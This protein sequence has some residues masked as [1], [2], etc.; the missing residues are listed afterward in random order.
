MVATN[1]GE[2]QNVVVVG[3]SASAGDPNITNGTALFQ[4][5]GSSKGATVPA[6]VTSTANG[7]DHQGLD[8]IEQLKPVAEDNSN[9][10]IAIVP[11]PLSVATYT[12]SL[13]TNFGANNTLNVKAT[14]GNVFSMYCR[15][16]NAAVRFIQL[17]NTATVP[18]NGNVPRLSFQLPATAAVIFGADFFTQF[19]INFST[20]IAFAFS[21]TDS[22]LTLGAAADQ[23][24]QIVFI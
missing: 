20:G 3:T 19:G 15:N 11:K 24:T 9:G 7:A 1:N 6:N 17:H 14:S 13:F 16:L 2:A 8:V 23:V 5:R 12:P 4:V 18:V 22:T 21:T 10:V